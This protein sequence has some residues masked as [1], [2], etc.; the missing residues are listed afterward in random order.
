MVRGFLAF[1]FGCLL[2]GSGP[3]NAAGIAIDATGEDTAAEQSF[4]GIAFESGD[5]F[6]ESFTIDISD[7][8]IGF[9]EA[10]FDFDGGIFN[11][12]PTA[13][14]FT[15]LNGLTEGDITVETSEPVM[16]HAGRPSILTLNFAEGSFGVGDSLRFFADTD[17]LMSDPL[18]GSGLGAASGVE[19]RVK[20]FDQ[21]EMAGLFETTDSGSGDGGSS[22]VDFAVPPAAVPLPAAAWLFLSA[23]GMLLGW[24][25]L[26]ARNG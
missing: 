21:A 2:L 24:R 20:L 15:E 22:A 16:G 25:G 19:V 5:G 23:I 9:D 18:P 12:Q 26:R 3:A 11:N 7:A 10:F 13:P 4:W 17:F 6:I 14:V 1:V 8:G